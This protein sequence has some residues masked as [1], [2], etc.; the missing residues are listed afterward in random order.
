MC[1]RLPRRARSSGGRRKAEAGAGERRAQRLTHRRRPPRSESRRIGA[2]PRVSRR[3]AKE[4]VSYCRAR[5]SRAALRIRMQTLLNRIRRAFV[6]RCHRHMSRVRRD[7]DRPSALLALRGGPAGL[8]IECARL[9][10]L[11]RPTR[12]WGVLDPQ[13]V[14]RAGLKPRALRLAH[15]IDGAR[16]GDHSNA[17]RSAQA[18]D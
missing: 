8:S 16:S 15:P 5:S 12:P 4:A 2:G 17:A 3:S 11:R 14:R 1:T 6:A 18:T 7:R 9:R 13:F 10:S